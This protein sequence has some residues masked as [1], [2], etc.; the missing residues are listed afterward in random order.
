MVLHVAIPRLVPIVIPREIQR[1]VGQQSLAR[2]E[3]A[4]ANPA[5]PTN[6]RCWPDCDIPTGDLSSAPGPG[7]LA[8]GPEF[9]VRSG[10]LIGRAAGLKGIVV[11][12]EGDQLA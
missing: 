1:K 11:A 5:R 12:L 3:V 7:Y 4:G 9:L 8:Q 2:R 6:G 10:C